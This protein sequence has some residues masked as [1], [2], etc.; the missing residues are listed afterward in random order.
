[1]RR[2]QFVMLVGGV[3]ASLPPAARARERKRRIGMLTGGAAGDA[4]GEGWV[5]AF[6]Q[7]LQAL[8]WQRDIDVRIDVRWGAS[9]LDRVA[10]FA[11]R[12]GGVQPDL[13]HAI[14][15]P[16]TAAI[17][18]ETRTIPVVFAIVSDPVGS[19]FVPAN[20]S[21]PGGNVTGFSNFDASLGGKWVQVL[22][23]VS[24]DSPCRA[25]V[26]S[27]RRAPNGL[28]QGSSLRPAGRSGGNCHSARPRFMER[29]RHR[30]N[31]NG[32]GPRSGSGPHRDAGQ[33][34]AEPPRNDH[35]VGGPSPRAGGLRISILRQ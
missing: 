18:R 5:Q 23:I 22:E 25:A 28:L 33:L 4:E 32:V 31:N 7:G 10:R 34:R 27:E 30:S 19:G 2:R 24:A 13:I 14:T 3:A 29:R 26:Q 15:T 21:R 20:L 8:G 12:A 17:L 16:A 6:L 35:L 11:K 9:D 1:M